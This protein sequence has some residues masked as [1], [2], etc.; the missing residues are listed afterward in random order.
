MLDR[1][2]PNESNR[3]CVNPPMAGLEDIFSQ[4][5]FTGG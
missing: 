3:H 5:S 1:M 2:T 4:G